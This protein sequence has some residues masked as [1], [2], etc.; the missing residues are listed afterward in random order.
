MATEKPGGWKHNSGA[1]NPKPAQGPAASRKSWQ[2]G[3]SAPKSPRRSTSRTG[4]FLLVGGFVGLLIAIVVFLI[5]WWQPQKYPALIVVAPNRPESLAWP[6][7]LAGASVGEG[8]QTWKTEHPSGTQLVAGREKTATPGSWKQAL[9]PKAESV[10]I[11]FA[12]SVG[13]DPAGPFVWEI[14]PAATA[15]SDSH[16]LYV[17]DI[18]KALAG[19]PGSQPKLI[20]FDPPG[21][22]VSWVHGSITDDFPRALRELEPD[23]KNIDGLAVMCSHDTDQR[24]WI[25]E[26]TGRTVF[27]QVFLDGVHGAGGTP[28]GSPITGATLLPYLKQEVEKWAI[29]NRDE[30]QTP[31]LLPGDSGN[32]RAGRVTLGSGPNEPFTPKGALSANPTPPALA[33]AWAVA[34]KLANRTPSPD[35]TDPARWKEFLELLLRWERLV[36]LPGNIAPTPADKVKILGDQLLAVG[37]TVAH[38]PTALPAGRAFGHAIIEINPGDFEAIWSAPSSNARAQEWN[39]QRNKPSQD[40]DTARRLA[41]TNAVLKRLVDEGPS[42]KTLKTADEVLALV[43]GTMDG[44]PVEGH[45]VRMLHQHLEKA[46]GRR[47]SLELLKRAIQLRRTAEEAAWVGGAAPG[48]YPHAEQVFRRTRGFVDEAD[49]FR[50]LGEDCLFVG[51]PKAWVD[52]DGYFARAEA[53]Y[54]VARQTAKVIATAL[55]F[56][57]RSFARLPFYARWLGGYR[58]KMSSADLAGLIA[59]FEAAAKAAHAIGNLE[60]A[61]ETTLAEFEREGRDG[62]KALEAIAKAHEEEAKQ[63]NNTVHPSN[64]HTLDGVL[65]VPFLPAEMRSQRLSFLRSISAG[66]APNPN[67]TTGVQATVVPARELSERQGRMA[68]AYLGDDIADS[69]QRLLQPKEGAWWESHR[70]VGEWIGKRLQ[71]CRSAAKSSLD[72]TKTGALAEGVPHLASASKSARL[73]SAAAPLDSKDGA[74]QI[75]QNYWRHA[76]LLWQSRRVSDDGWADVGVQ[77]PDQ[78]FCR[79]ASKLL[80]T[81]ARQLAGVNEANLNPQ[82]M[83]RRNDACLSEEAYSPSELVVSATPRRVIADEA[84]WDAGLSIQPTTG[85][86]IGYPI[87]SLGLPGAPYHRPNAELLGRMRIEEFAVQ[88]AAKIDRVFQFQSL[89]RTNAPSSEG[90]LRGNVFYRG[91][92]YEAETKVVLAGAPNLEWNYTPP[93]G[94]AAFAILADNDLVAGAVTL[95]LDIT[96]TMTFKIAGTESTRIAEA[97][98]G[99]GELLKVI[100]KGTVVTIATFYGIEKKMK[101]ELVCKPFQIDGTINQFDKKMALVNAVKLAPEESITPLAGSIREMLHPDRNAQ[102]W[103]EKFTGT[104]TYIVLTDGEDNWTDKQYP[105]AVPDAYGGKT[106]AEIII[107]ALRDTPDDVEAHLVFFGIDGPAGEAVVKQLESVEFLENFRKPPKTPAKLH[108]GTKSGAAFARDLKAAVLPRVNYLGDTSQEK[109]KVTLPGEDIYRTS[110]ALAPAVYD[111]FDLGSPQKLQLNAGDRVLLRARSEANDLLLSIPAA[112]YDLPGSPEY[113][114]IV[115]SQPGSLHLS[116][117][118]FAFGKE[119]TAS[120]DLSMLATLEPR[121]EGKTQQRLQAPRPLFAWFDVGYADGQPASATLTPRV[122]IENRIGAISPTWSVDLLDWDRNRGGAE[123]IRKPTIEAFWLD[124]VP[125]PLTTYTVDMKNLAESKANARKQASDRGQAVDLVDLAIETVGPSKY[126]TVR[127]QYAKPGEFVFLRPGGWK[128]KDAKLVTLQEQHSY[129]DT[130]AR[131]TAR[132]GPLAP[133]DFNSTQKLELFSVAA[134]RDHARKTEH[135]A[136]LTFPDRPLEVY[137]FSNKITLTEPKE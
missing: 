70:Q 120:R 1:N 44:R 82:E 132:F 19:H 3:G 14:D 111:L 41:W 118:K 66:L 11:Y 91:H 29:V 92:T 88:R 9:D 5:Q 78:W 71:G 26:S 131:Y 121:P 65:S 112:V 133:D 122:R 110:K 37:A 20:V 72:K 76:F 67:Q 87:L 60:A 84:V 75:E 8:F 57:D 23:I 117:P 113:E 136:K 108:I 77:T 73:A 58:G 31:M 25:S 64:W 129:Y 39:G 38:L 107:G 69:K 137:D 123:T 43:D 33:D 4:R 22:P 68:L 85:R 40:N 89:G 61:P 52:A 46:D 42:A 21:S 126:L 90:K 10:V 79:K 56:R 48:A 127:L 18:L 53:G 109:L 34:E 12:T 96:P 86:K 115:R 100:P 124:G 55:Q 15:P 116:I 30:K 128:D 119:T 103:P 45:F 135:A 36:R 54:S 105:G 80:L 2:S 28:A 98:K 6:E 50:R 13:V 27:G 35:T 97:K 16:K 59:N 49:A 51:E 106:P 130:H 32:D 17:R 62:A 7:N 134:L 102:F 101:I 125:L 94:K 99:F 114:R 47:P 24:A 93:S 95:V 104:R 83:K 63:L 74:L 81:E